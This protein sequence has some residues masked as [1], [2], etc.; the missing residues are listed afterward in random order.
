MLKLIW[1]KKPDSKRAQNCTNVGSN[2][3][4]NA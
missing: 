1:E 3:Y 2:V 4:V